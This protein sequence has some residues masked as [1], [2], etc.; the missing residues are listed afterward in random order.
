MYVNVKLCNGINYIPKSTEFFWCNH[1]Y[2]YFTMVRF[3]FRMTKMHSCWKAFINDTIENRRKGHMTRGGSQ[4]WIGRGCGAGS[5]GPIPMFRGNF[6]QKRYPCLGIFPKKGPICSDFFKIFG[7][8]YANPGKFWVC[9]TIWTPTR[10]VHS[11]QVN[12]S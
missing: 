8:R 6:S 7:V 10:S 4:I 3:I 12:D 1:I 9:N 5:E 2:D 11:N